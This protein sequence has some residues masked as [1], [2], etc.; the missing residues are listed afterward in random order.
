M[1]LFYASFLSP[2]SRE[3]YE[4]LVARIAT[5]VPGSLR[6]VPRGSHHLTHAF[7][8]E[9][10]E[11]EVESFLGLLE[12]LA[13]LPAIR[14]ALGP[15]SVL[16][17]RGSPRL[18]KVDLLEGGEQVSRLQERLRREL[19]GLDPSLAGRSKPPHVTI[20]RFPRNVRRDKARRVEESLS[21]LGQVSALGDELLSRVELIRSRLTRE[22]PIYESLGEVRLSEGEGQR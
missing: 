15:P 13:D 2:G 8:G 6:P 14:F 7:L 17:G 21:Q 3:A 11:S 22:G 9:I 20:A 16:F 12:G 10:A 1:R 4:S 19:R 5:E 18:V